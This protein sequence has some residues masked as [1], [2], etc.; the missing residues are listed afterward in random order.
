MKMA[1][2]PDEF[3]RVPVVLP[4]T[5]FKPGGKKLVVIPTFV[6]TTLKFVLG[7]TNVCNQRPAFYTVFSTYRKVR[8]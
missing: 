2:V 1:L 7:P 3:A 5:F 4:S 6:F 8:A